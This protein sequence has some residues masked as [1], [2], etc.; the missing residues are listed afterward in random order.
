[1]M[2]D[3][4]QIQVVMLLNVDRQQLLKLN[5]LMIHLQKELNDAK[6]QRF[7]KVW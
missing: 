7:G 1:M 6:K 4:V 5:L 2:D 3:F